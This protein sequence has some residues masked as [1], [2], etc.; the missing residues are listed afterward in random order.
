M[1]FRGFTGGIAFLKDIPL[2]DKVTGLMPQSW[3]DGSLVNSKIAVDLNGATEYLQAEVAEPFNFGDT[4]FTICV[5]FELDSTSGNKP[6]FDKWLGTGNKRS[7]YVAH[8]GTKLRFA[9]DS[10]GT[11]SGGETLFDTTA[12]ISTG[13]WYTAFFIH[14]ATANTLRINCWSGGTEQFDESTSHSGGAYSES[15]LAPLIGS[16]QTNV[17]FVN[18]QIDQTLV[19]DKAL[20]DT[21]IEDI[22]NSGDGLNYSDLT[23]SETFFGNIISWYDFNT[24]YRLGK[25]MSEQNHAVNLDGSADYLSSTSTDFNFYDAGGDQPFSIGMWV[26]PDDLV[27]AEYFFSNSDDVE[28]QYR[29][30]AGGSGKLFFTLYQSGESIR[31]GTECD[32]LTISDDTL[33]H[34][35][36]TYDGSATNSGMKIYVDG[37]SGSSY[38]NYNIGSFTALP[39]VSQLNIGYSPNVGFPPTFLGGDVDEFFVYGD[40]LTPSEVSTLY[41][42]G[43]IVDASTL[44]T[45]SLI[46]SYSFN[47]G[48]GNIGSDGYGSNDLTPTSLTEASLIGGSGSLDLTGVSVTSVDAVAG[49][50]AGNAG[51]WEGITQLSDKSGNGNNITQTTMT[52]TPILGNTY[53]G[54]RSI[55]L[56]GSNDAMSGDP[57]PFFD[58]VTDKAYSLTV[59]LK[60]YTLKNNNFILDADTFQDGIYFYFRVDGTWFYRQY[61]ASTAADKRIDPSGVLA[62]SPDTWYS[63][64]VTYS[65][66]NGFN[67]Y[68]NGVDQGVST[69][70]NGS[71][72]AVEN[73]NYAVFAQATTG[74]DSFDGE[75]LDFQVHDKELDASQVSLLKRYHENTFGITL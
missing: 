5:T 1:L 14:D 73:A 11:F 51:D 50:I 59:L 62:V 46:S 36:V 19:F 52:S 40:V 4:D 63:W 22:V 56:D 67:L 20:S 55:L 44:H 41:N 37:V 17:V 33:A 30:S 45:S 61:D 66:S 43:T 35:V 10:L 75:I 49:N 15:T 6:L 7:Y 57:F 53:N 16:D 18:G 47:E 69:I 24:V 54:Y 3:F 26:K 29:L 28:T 27:S 9:I 48:L 8:N 64:T 12:T 58:G 65:P 39:D 25:N 70:T 34:L 72:T 2:L 21:E 71:Y 42:N 74:T 38:S 13:T 68:V 23:E 32:D 31:L 60:M